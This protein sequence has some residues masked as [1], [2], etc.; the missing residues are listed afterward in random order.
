MTKKFYIF[1]VITM[2]MA[3]FILCTS[4]TYAK[5][6]AT[7]KEGYDPLNE[8]TTYVDEIIFNDDISDLSYYMSTIYYE[9]INNIA[10]YQLIETKIIRKR[11]IHGDTDDNYIKT[12]FI[13]YYDTMLSRFELWYNDTLCISF[14]HHVLTLT[15]ETN[16]SLNFND[17]SKPEYQHTSRVSLGE[18]VTTIEGTNP[19]GFDASVCPGYED[20]ILTK[21]TDVIQTVDLEYQMNYLPTLDEIIHTDFMLDSGLTLSAE[22]NELYYSDY[23]P[24][25]YGIVDQG[26]HY[27]KC[28]I[29]YED[30]K[31]IVVYK[32]N[33]LPMIDSV[34]SITTSVERQ[35][36]EA[37]MKEQIAKV[38][39]ENYTI[40]ASNY[41]KDYNTPGVYYVKVI[42]DHN[43]LDVTAYLKITVTDVGD[44]KIKLKKGASLKT[45]YTKTID[46]SKLDQIF[47][48]T[49]FNCKQYSCEA[50]EYLNNKNTPGIYEIHVKAISEDEEMYIQTYY[51]T[52]V[53]DI[54]PNVILKDGTILKYSYTNEIDI[55]GLL[56]NLEISDVST[57]NYTYDADS[58]LNNKNKPGN[59]DI[60]VDVYDI[61]EN[62]TY[63]TISIELVDDVA[64]KIVMEDIYTTKDTYYD[65]NTLKSMVY[66][67]DEI[68]GRLG[69]DNI[70]INDI[71]GYKNNY[72]VK[73]EY[74]FSIKASDNSGNTKQATFKIYV[75]EN[76]EDIP[77]TTNPT[78]NTGD[79]TNVTTIVNNIAITLNR[80][81]KLTKD[82]FINYLISKGYLDSNKTYELE[83][84]YF[85]EEVLNEDS[86]EVSVKDSENNSY[87]YT[88][89]MKDNEATYEYQTDNIKEESGNN[90]PLIITIVVI[91]VLVLASGI[92]IFIIYKKRH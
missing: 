44:N 66:A 43:G 90:L 53:D 46:L 40:D 61:Y 59:Y 27:V 70:I 71:N 87:S 86:Y 34:P 36:T 1:S 31:Y 9:S 50:T 82:E 26:V 62:H 56:D 83:S 77:V 12:V 48:F 60:V 57:Y 18:P 2:L 78:V 30:K 92:L 37:E 6:E 54:A 4:S 42:Y 24:N 80:D 3:L 88:I 38:N 58:Y 51:I 64:P 19:K 22:N 76:E 72:D 20:I 89:N 35:V 63:Y 25:E 33:V 81:T 8:D 73:G 13:P 17:P 52:V 69:V 10:E 21:T 32:I 15:V 74:N 91:I 55:L 68:D 75:I 23:N 41:Y 14:E 65:E 45:S 7:Y 49:Y 16:N 85:E 39:L 47:D 79:S 11:V 67:T 29:T 5:T 28:Y 84:K